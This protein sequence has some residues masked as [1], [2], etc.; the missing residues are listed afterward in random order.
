MAARVAI[1]DFSR[2]THLNVTALRHHHEVGL[3]NPTEIDADSGYRFYAPDSVQIAQVI[4]RSVLA[5][6]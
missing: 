5:D 3:L 1:G 4:H 2:M 6:Q